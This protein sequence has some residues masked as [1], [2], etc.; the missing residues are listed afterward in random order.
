MLYLASVLIE[1]LEFYI[2][3]QIVQIDRVITS[4]YR[5][6]RMSFF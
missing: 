2:V 4:V 6:V 5:L 1:R 3:I